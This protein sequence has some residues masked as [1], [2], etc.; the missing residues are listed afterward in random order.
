MYEIGKPNT[1]K[2][3]P[4]HLGLRTRIKQ[5]AVR[6]F[7]F[8]SSEVMHDLVIGLFIN[9]SE[10]VYQFRDKQQIYNIILPLPPYHWFFAPH[11]SPLI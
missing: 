9:R 5:L 1:Q 2:V 11:S 10:F 6:Q 7:A 8:R 4:K 3:E